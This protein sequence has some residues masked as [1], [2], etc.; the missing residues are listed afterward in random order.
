VAI[1]A[2]QSM[3]ARGILARRSRLP[4][5]TMHEPAP[6][7]RV[8]ATLF[9]RPDEVML[10]LGAGGELLV[11][12]VRALLS[13]LVLVLPLAAALDGAATNRTLVGLGVAVLVNIVAQV[14]LALARNHRRHHWLP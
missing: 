2:R 11:A 9:G 8:L 1:H 14:W 10:E 5:P 7:K 6:L 13:L 3:R 4:G 12:K